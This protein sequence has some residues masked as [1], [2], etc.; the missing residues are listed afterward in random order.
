MMY[1]DYFEFIE[2]LNSNFASCLGTE[3]EFFTAYL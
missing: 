3:K 1:L 2:L